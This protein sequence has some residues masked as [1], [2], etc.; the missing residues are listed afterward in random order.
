MALFAGC[1]C[2]QQRFHAPLFPMSVHLQLQ[3]SLIM[4]SNEDL[5]ED[6]EARTG[7]ARSPSSPSQRPL[8]LNLSTFGRQDEQQVRA[9]AASARLPSLS[10]TLPGSGG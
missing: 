10:P 2:G 7:S 9:C 4:E 6:E 3:D 1:N 5:E 8:L